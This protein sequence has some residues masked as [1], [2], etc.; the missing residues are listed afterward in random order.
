MHTTAFTSPPPRRAAGLALIRDEN[1]RVL[2]LDKAYRQGPAR[3]GLPGGLAEPGEPASVACR[4][5]VLREMGL[6]LVPRGLLVVHY[7][8]DDG[9]VKEGHNFVFDCGSIPSGTPLALPDD[10]FRGHLWLD[11]EEL[12]DAVAPYTEWRISN[13]LEAGEGGPVRYLVG[14]PEFRAAA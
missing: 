4:R 13:A 3:F 11:V 12:C 7:M 6:T 10:E 1:G 14:H 2:L 8:P 5:Q 9:E